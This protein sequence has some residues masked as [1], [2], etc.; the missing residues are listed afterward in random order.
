MILEQEQQKQKT[1][2]EGKNQR[3]RGRK[4]AGRRLRFF[5][6]CAGKYLWNISWKNAASHVK[7]WACGK[8][9]ND[10]E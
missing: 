8:G 5:K 4:T 1:A 6:K 3:D 7:A 10:L 2:Q 9:R